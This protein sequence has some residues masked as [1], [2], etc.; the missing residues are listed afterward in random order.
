MAKGSVEVSNAIALRDWAVTIQALLDGTQI[1]LLRKGGIVEET[2]DF[3]LISPQFYLL[4]AYEHQKLHLLKPGEQHRLEKVLEH[5]RQ[6]GQEIELEAYGEVTDEIGITD[7]KVL[8]RLR[9][10]HIWTDEFAEERLKWKPRK[11]LH[12][13]LVRVYRLTDKVE[14]PM[15][16]EYTGCKSWVT[17]EGGPIVRQAVPVLSDEEYA[18]RVQS[19]KSALSLAGHD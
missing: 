10:D 18:S 6:D 5:W 16:P 7:Q 14:L 19:I 17:L 13:L 8:E 9:D 1:L 15:R 3:K 11:P 2:R 12:L 4:P